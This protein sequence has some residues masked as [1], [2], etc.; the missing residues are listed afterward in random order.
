MLL[1]R[2]NYDGFWLMDDD[3]IPDKKQLGYLV[4]NLDHYDYIS[5]MVV[6]KEDT[7]VL[8]FGGCPVSEFVQYAENDRIVG[9][10]NP[11]NG[12]LFSRRLV[13][14]VGYPVRDM[15]IWG[16]E[17]NYGRRC[18][19]AGFNPVMDVRAVHVHPKDRQPRVQLSENEQITVP[20]EDW[21]LYCYVR[22]S[23]Y[24]VRT[25]SRTRHYL[26][27]CVDTW[28]QYTRYFTYR[29]FNW[30]RLGIVYRAIFDGYRKDL[31]RLSCYKK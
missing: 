26:R 3:G 15:F 28:W 9:A 7:S 12:V 22:N 24:N 23:I 13:E 29:D 31:S 6:S 27:I 25:I 11:F 17:I 21:K 19:K 16:D 1:F 4:T 8:S 10:A 20:K 5:P 18:I 14:K 2:S 30:R